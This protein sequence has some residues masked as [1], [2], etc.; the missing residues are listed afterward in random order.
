[1]KGKNPTLSP[2]LSPLTSRNSETVVVGT[3]RFDTRS[4][5][6]I[7]VSPISGNFIQL[8]GHFLEI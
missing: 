6:N 2:S 8:M 7:I 1:M 4:F 5:Y 3:P